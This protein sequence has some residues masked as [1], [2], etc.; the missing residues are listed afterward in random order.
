MI[1]RP[2]YDTSHRVHEVQIMQ[3]VF[4]LET[5]KLKYK[6]SKWQHHRYYDTKEAAFDALRDL[7][8][9][10]GYYVGYE[11]SFGGISRNR[12]RYNQL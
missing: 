7:R 11:E 6:S 12:Y 4:D 2:K 8:K 10:K 1:A 9:V 3:Y 5:R